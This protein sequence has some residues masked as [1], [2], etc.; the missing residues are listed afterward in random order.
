MSFIVIRCL[1]AVFHTLLHLLVVGP[2][3]YSPSICCSVVIFFFSQLAST[4]VHLWS[5]CHPSSVTHAQ[6]ILID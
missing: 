5:V 6:D 1:P 3:Q 2:L 4:D